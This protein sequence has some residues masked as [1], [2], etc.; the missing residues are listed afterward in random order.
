MAS[1]SIHIEWANRTQQ[2]IAHLLA[3]PSIHSPWIAIAAF[4][5]ALHIVEAVFANDTSVGN[6]SNHDERERELKKHRKYEHIYK[7]YAFLKRA[8][9]NARYLAGGSSFD[10]YLPPDQV[11]AELLE[12]RLHQIEQSAMKFLKNPSALVPVDSALK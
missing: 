12:H 6:T 1:E 7:N 9:V 8:S 4:Y 10:A 2:T 3:D 11:V 5:K